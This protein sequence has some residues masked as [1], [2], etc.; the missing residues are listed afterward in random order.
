MTPITASGICAVLSLM[1]AY[2]PWN[3]RTAALLEERYMSALLPVPQAVGLRIVAEVDR[4]FDRRP[5]VKV[6]IEWAGTLTPAPA[7]ASPAHSGASK[8]VGPCPPH[9]KA[10]MR[11]F[12]ARK[13]REERGGAAGMTRFG[14]GVS[15][16]LAP[17]QV[18]P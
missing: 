3:E 14:A 1:E 2:S 7:F 8:A 18:L 11:D 13:A 16:A 4:H 6:L 12:F 17:E 10:Q 5:S 15:A 9:I